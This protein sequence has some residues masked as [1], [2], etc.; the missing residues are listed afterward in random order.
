MLDP[1]EE[2]MI[3]FTLDHFIS[4]QKLQIKTMTWLPKYGVL[5]TLKYIQKIQII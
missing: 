4:Y 5:L 1:Q 3:S 2:I